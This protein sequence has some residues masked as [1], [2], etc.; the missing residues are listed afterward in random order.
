[1]FT[2]GVFMEHRT[3]GYS[4]S[5]YEG[6]GYALRNHYFVRLSP[7]SLDW[8]ASNDS[9]V[10]L[11]FTMIN[12]LDFDA[13][14]VPAGI[15]N[16]SL[17]DLEHQASDFFHLVDP[18]K[19]IIAEDTCEGFWSVG[20]N[21]VPGLEQLMAHILDDL[22]FTRVGMISGL[23]RSQGARQREG[24]FF[25]EMEKRGLEVP[26][27]RFTRGVFTGEC[28]DIIDDFL[29]K[30]TDLECIVC[31]NDTLALKLYERMRLR[32]LEPGKDIAVTGFDDV[33]EA[34]LVNPP[35]TTVRLSPFASGYHAGREA[36]HLCRGEPQH[37]KSLDSSLIIR[38]SCGEDLMSDQRYLSHFLHQ[39]PIAVD[40]LVEFMLKRTLRVLA[41]DVRDDLRPLVKD[42]VTG[43]IA[44]ARDEESPGTE[45]FARI[46]KMFRTNFS[47]YNINNFFSVFTTFCKELLDVTPEEHKL[48]LYDKF[49]E[50][51]THISMFYRV[52]TNDETNK[53]N[54]LSSVCLD[55]SK[56]ALSGA[57][58]PKQAL[59]LL[60]ECMNRIGFRDCD[61]M[62]FDKPL[63]SSEFDHLELP[64]SVI[65]RA[66]SRDNVIR[67]PNDLEVMV[68]IKDIIKRLGKDEP[69]ITSVIPL[70]M[71]GYLLG[72]FTADTTNIDPT[73]FY[74]AAIQISFSVLHMS[75]I[76]QE[77]RLIE[78]LNTDNEAILTESHHDPLTGLMNRRGLM[79][80]IDQIKH[81]DIGRY[82]A[83]FYFDLDDFK[84]IND[85]FGHDTGDEAIREAGN[86]L[87]GTF[88]THDL[89]ARM[90]GD[91]FCAIAISDH[92]INVMSIKE[93]INRKAD[94]FNMS[95]P[96]R[97]SYSAGVVQ[98]T[99]TSDADFD[100]KIKNADELLYIDKK[101]KKARKS[102]GSQ[103]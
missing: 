73:F 75:V 101:A 28:E 52:R 10:R 38:R 97:L 3:G 93:R 74:F 95:H 80:Q 88:R 67:I 90:G 92:P 89:V 24:V 6:I 82:A 37:Y 53:L 84:I 21:G 61:I 87:R 71:N 54:A 9:Q 70:D 68:P 77:Q 96:Y 31:A 76:E 41:P 49:I 43:M 16:S 63:D 25:K 72:F 64:D 50:I 46:S 30:N 81:L 83:V 5:F 14:I 13:F 44:I 1:M 15:L 91:E 57:D 40:E 56:Q 103:A 36:V 58:R 20:K 34:A 100:A 35:L 78:L 7:S 59:R 33:P 69:S 66:E 99:I 29:D 32:G 85:T 18:K 4:H 27:H 19:I 62:L 42:V 17:V 94:I 8:R 55:I 65:L 47:F 26:E 48:S 86:I 79:F 11:D 23:A 45:N 22:G 51:Q 60:A 2:I 39:D 98:F 12:L 102:E